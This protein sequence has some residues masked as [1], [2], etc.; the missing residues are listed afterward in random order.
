MS[1]VHESSAVTTFLFTDLEGSTRLW[2]HEPQRMRS[3]LARHDA[4]ARS[5]VERHR[6][7]VVKMIGDG[8]HAVFDDP[9]DAVRASIAFQQALADGHD[10]DGLA[11]RARC[12]LHAGVHERR[13]NDYFGGVVNRAARIMGAAHGGQ[14]LLSQTVAALVHDRLP[15]GVSLRDLGAVRLRDLATPEHVFQV[16]QPG[17]RNEFPALR[18]LEATPNNLPRQWTS[19]VGRE[20]EQSEIARC[21][22]ETRVLTLFGMGGLGKT[23]LSLQVAADAMDDFPDGVWFVELAPLRDA[24]LVAQAVASALGVKEEAGRPVVEALA[25]FVTDRRLLLVLDNCEHLAQACAELA[26]RLLQSGSQ[27]KILA[28][29]REPLRVA[30]ETTFHVPALATP[31]AD[32]R[33]SVDALNQSEAV[34]LF[35]DRARAAQPAFRLDADN[36][37]AVAAIC[38]RL[39]GIP[40]AIELAAARVRAMS[41]GAIAARLDDRFRLLTGGERTASPRQQTLRGLIDWSYELLS[42]SERAL[43]QRLSMFAGG[44]TLEA[45]EHVGAA[46]DVASADV[47]DGLTQLVEKSLAMFE[48]DRGRYRLLETVRQYAQEKLDES[49][50][51]KAARTRHLAHY[52]ALAEEARPQLVGR[53]QRAWLAR[54]DVEREN[55]LAAHAYA[56]RADDGAQLGLR[57]VDAVKPYWLNRGLLE[58]GYRMTIEALAREGAH[59]RDRFRCTVLFDA[60]QLGCAMGLYAQARELLDESLAIA[61]EIADTGRVAKVLQPLGIASLGLGDLAVARRHFEEALALAR[62]LGNKRDVAAALNALAQFHRMDDQL[63]AAVPLYEQVVALARELGDRDSTAIGLLNLAMASMGGGSAARAPAMLLEALTIARETG[64][65]PAGQSVIEVTAALASERNAW[66]IAARLYG[67]AEAQ[68]V[69]TGLKRDPVDEAFIAP[70]IAKARDALAAAA[71]EE[72]AAA[73]RALSYEDAIEETRN[74]LTSLSVSA[75]IHSL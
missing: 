4:I 58:L 73:G 19:F 20:A 74:W 12:G 9:L 49:G 18:S 75:S 56:D 59:M 34:R 15:D 3:A 29:S 67:C 31:V 32:E 37:S 72:A 68:A 63:G 27:F 26:T 23:R 42:E 22:G 35:V 28:S 16:V 10:A 45:A 44:F 17:L 52:V 57:L 66:D 53:E 41:V 71:F 50:E 61:R 39:D 70:R 62:Q 13:D 11:L 30:G 33:I 43:L 36:A 69:R 1:A 48:D 51:A 2:E 55:L 21:L 38:R 46:R 64:S 7:V 40:L 65:S 25:K 6:G 60:G 8:M 54:L 24:A 5:I 47:L 14:V